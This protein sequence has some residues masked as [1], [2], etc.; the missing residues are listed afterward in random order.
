[1]DRWFSIGFLTGLLLGGAIGLLSA[2]CEGPATRERIKNAAQPSLVRLSA[3]RVR[4]KTAAPPDLTAIKQ[5][6]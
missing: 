4:L 6:I 5:A 1:M 2:P 3:L